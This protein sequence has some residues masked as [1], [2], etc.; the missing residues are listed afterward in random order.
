MGSAIM[1]A[2]TKATLLVYK[3][4]LHKDSDGPD[5]KQSWNDRSLIGMYFVDAD[6]AGGYSEGTNEDPILVYS[7]AGYL[8][9]YYGCPDLWVSKMQ[10]EISLYTVK[11]HCPEYCNERSHPICRPSR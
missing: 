3:E 11:T 1:E 10:A 5:R 7:P 9:Y 6:F 4:I 2:N 8:I